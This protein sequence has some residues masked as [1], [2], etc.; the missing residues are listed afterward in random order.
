MQIIIFALNAIV[1][2]LLSN[3]I[4]KG[5]EK[6]RGKSL[7]NRHLAFFIVFFAL[8]VVSFETLKIVLENVG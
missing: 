5:I 6:K 4:L 2:Y 7:K 1:V 3:W 8:I